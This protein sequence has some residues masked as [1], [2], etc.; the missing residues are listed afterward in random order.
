MIF[1]V[2]IPFAVAGSVWSVFKLKQTSQ[3]VRVPMDISGNLSLGS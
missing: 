3:K 2:N 1:I